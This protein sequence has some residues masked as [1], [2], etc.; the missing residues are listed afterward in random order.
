MSGIGLLRTI[1][2]HSGGSQHHLLAR[3]IA[4]LLIH[5]PASA[6]PL[7]PTLQPE[8]IFFSTVR[9]ILSEPTWDRVSPLH[10]VSHLPEWNPKS[11]K[12]P[13]RLYMGRLYFWVSLKPHCPLGPSLNMPDLLPPPGLC[14]CCPFILQMSSHVLSQ[15]LAS[16]LMCHLIR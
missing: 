4:S 9:M 10:D 7:L 5:F 6:L 13:G 12:G 14:T 15:L 1:R 2:Y 16:L 11:L 8:S 3:I